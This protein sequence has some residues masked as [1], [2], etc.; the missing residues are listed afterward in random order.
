MTTKRS[1]RP[2]VL[3]FLVVAALLAALPVGGRTETLADDS[4]GGLERGGSLKGPAIGF[5]LKAT[6]SY[7]DRHERSGIEPVSSG[8]LSWVELDVAGALAD[9]VR[10]CF[11]LAGNGGLYNDPIT[12][13]PATAGPSNPGEIGSIGVR[14]AYIE[15]GGIP[16]TR[17]GVGTFMPGWGVFQDRASHDWALIDLPLIYT[18]PDFRYLGWQNSGVR[19]SVDPLDQVGVDLYYLNGY[20]PDAMGNSETMVAGEGLDTGKAWGGRVRLSLGPLSLFG[21]Y[22]SEGWEEDTEGGPSP[23][24][25]RSVA[26]M[27]GAELTIEQFWLLFE[28]TDIVIEDYQLKLTGDMTDL[29]SIGGHVTLGWRP[30]DYWLFLARWE[31]VDPN[32]SDTRK[33]FNRSRF[34]QVNQWTA[35]VE[36]RLAD[37]AR[38]RVNYV[39]PLEEGHNVDLDKGK[40]GGRYQ[41]VQNNYFRLEVAGW[42]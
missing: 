36:Y 11:E 4:A 13:A 26:W 14:R 21:S 37:N 2:G 24:V 3:A 35:G 29:E 30:L 20:F 9:N 10:Y 22:M 5:V 15:I 27:A 28:W 1:R 40:V 33:T 25:Q 32:T 12:G 8:S 7:R 23:E 6:Y 38:F 17:L 42:R 34:D 31:W 39:I 19:L 18:R 41:D 16:F